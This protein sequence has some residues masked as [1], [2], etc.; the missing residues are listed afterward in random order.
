MI[1]IVVS[2]VSDDIDNDFLTV[3]AGPG[4]V[5]NDKTEC[6]D[7]LMSKLGVFATAAAILF[8]SSCHMRLWV[9]IVQFIAVI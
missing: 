6:E 2:F 5:D 9:A 7:A 3:A 1:T 4:S 8:S